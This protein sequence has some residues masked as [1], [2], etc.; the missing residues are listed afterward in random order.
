MA[1]P[2]ADADVPLVERARR[3]DKRAFEMLAIKYQRRVQRLVGRMVRDPERVQDIVQDTFLSAY[4]AL[5][6]FRGDSAFYTWL[7]R[8]AVNTARKALAEIQRDPLVFE[9]SLAAS[10][11]D[12][13]GTFPG[14]SEPSSLETPEALLGSRQIARAVEGAVAAL[15]AD[16]R[17]A[18][19]LREVE[20][21]GYE[22]IAI[23]M[24]C[25]VGTVRSRIFRAREAVSQALEPVL[26]RRPGR[27]W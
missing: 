15:P 6:G 10:A 27:R 23:L 7:Y 26:D 8:I 2:V 14:G 5:P 11:E 24:N 12:D 1:D 17:Q 13:Q 19:V 21:L 25:P 9:S 3:G 4:R 20:G 22:E 16:L 18:L